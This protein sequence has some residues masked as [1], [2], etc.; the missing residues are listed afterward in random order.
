MLALK[1]VKSFTPLPAPSLT[2]A[3]LPGYSFQ[4][5]ANMGFPFKRV[6][7]S[8]FFG[9]HLQRSHAFYEIKIQAMSSLIYQEKLTNRE[10]PP[11]A[12]LKGEEICALIQKLHPFSFF[13]FFFSFFLFLSFFLFFF[14]NN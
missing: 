12:P 11:P 3:S 5:L 13:F 10:G 9:H 6:T 2:T 4:P 7:A 8:F 14:F 1:Q